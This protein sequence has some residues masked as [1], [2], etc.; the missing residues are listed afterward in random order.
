MKIAFISL[1][2]EKLP[3]PVIPVGI[4]YIIANTPEHHQ[5]ELWDL[6]FEDKPKDFLRSK[7]GSFNPEVIAV[8]IR[9]V[10]NNSYTGIEDNLNYYKSIFSE[11][12][13]LTKSK[14]ILGGSGFSIMSE[15]IMQ[16]LKP[17]LGIFGEGEETFNSVLETL[18]DRRGDFSQIPNVLY[19]NDNKLEVN[20]R[21][22]N[23]VDINSIK[24]P[25]IEYLVSDY[26]DF[27][28]INSIQTKR[29]CTYN[30]KYCSYPKI[31]GN[32]CRL[33]TPSK[34]A[35]EIRSCQEQC[36]NINHFFIVD[37]VFNS[38][39]EHA[40]Q[41][42][43]EL[44][45]AN[46]KTPWTCY[47][48]PIDFDEELAELMSEA[49][50]RGVE[51]G[52]DSGNNKILQKLHKG[53]DTTAILNISKLCKKNG[54]KDCHTFML[55]TP[56]ETIEDVKITLEFIEELKPFCS[57]I[58]PWFSYDMASDKPKTHNSILEMLKQYSKT[59]NNCIIPC[60]NKNFDQKLFKFLRKKNFQGPLWYHI[61]LVL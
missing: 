51:I 22:N 16:F 37:S 48:N 57:I 47:C 19:F 7:I 26:F 31:E 58:M 34:V 15:E 8:G 35:E 53:F 38:P 50:C 60:L 61:D 30:C 24:K 18:E 2:R 6:C 49:N 12:R 14:I 43:R 29:G 23:F 55:G 9:N 44:I 39:A 42:C 56:D 52:A 46:L 33:R 40:K 20:K 21:S 5:K 10:N 36:G 1:N 3:D 32:I 25:A 4:L 41:I 11:I 27:M 28:G 17:D 45:D 54:I 59:K 13:S